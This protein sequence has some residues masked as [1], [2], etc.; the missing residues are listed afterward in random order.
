[1]LQREL[2]KLKDFVLKSNILFG[3]LAAFS[4]LGIY[5]YTI[6]VWEL[7]FPFLLLLVLPFYIFYSKVK[8]NLEQKIL[9][10]SL[11][12]AFLLTLLLILSTSIYDHNVSLIIGIRGIL[13]FLI[14]F[15]AAVFWFLNFLFTKL[16]TVNFISREKRADRKFFFISWTVLLISWI[17]YLAIFFPAIMSPDSIDQWI[18]AA[19]KTGLYNH[20]P[21]AHTLL[22]RYT[23][24]LTHNNPIGYSIAQ[25]ITLSFFMALSV[26]WLYKKGLQKKIVYLILGFFALHPLN[27]LY[28]MTV[29]KDVTFSIFLALLTLVIAEIILEERNENKNNLYFVFLSIIALGVMLF[30]NNG[31][32]IVLPSALLM[33]IVLKNIR[34]KL[35]LSFFLAISS[36]LLITGPIFTYYDIKK[37]SLTESLGIPIQQISRTVYENGEISAKDR[38][39]IE[40]VIPIEEVREHYTTAGVDPIKFN[41]KFKISVIERNKREYFILWRNLFFDNPRLY[42]SAYLDATRGF[43]NPISRNWSVYYDIYQNK[44]GLVQNNNL[45]QLR[46]KILRFV[47]W[48]QYHPPYYFFW[49]GI[50]FNY[51]MLIF[52]AP[53]IY[54]KKYKYLLVIVPFVLN[55]A[56]LLIATPIATSTRYVYSS[57]LI[58]P[59]VIF[60]SLKN[61]LGSIDKHKK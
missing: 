11:L 12:I 60:L 5:K 34:R 39:S 23:I 3:I 57:F 48:A 32:Y 1:M 50:N 53:F 24:F 16:E 4:A 52:S 10:S 59:I 51:L 13:Y 15:F 6:Q 47:E 26:W 25:I 49:S 40:A 44:Y 14:G 9:I 27:G 21:V 18:Q 58:F 37:S 35:G 30:R 2:S 36:Y 22:M 33:I 45:P 56:T 41:G 61:D 19:G 8:V 29:W 7:D 20:H 42:V 31:I 55:W 17:P 38:A 28:S 43:W 46:A 54:R